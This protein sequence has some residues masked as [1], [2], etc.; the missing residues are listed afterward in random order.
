MDGWTGVEL[1]HL[2]A[3]AAIHE[4]GSFRGAADRLGYVQS[5]VSQQLAQLELLVGTRLVDRARGHAPPVR[6]TEAGVLLLD[7]AGRI[8]GQLAAAEA[9]LRVHA[10]DGAPR[11]R[12]GVDQSVATRLVPAALQHLGAAHP[13]ISVELDEASSDRVHLER[14]AAGELDAAFAELPLGSDSLRFTEVLSDPCV[15]LL[16][17]ASALANADDDLELA[18]LVAAPLVTLAGWPMMNLI[19]SHLRNAGLEP[20]TAMRTNTCT[21]A[22]ALVGTGAGAAILPRL[23]VNEDDPRVVVRD[24]SALLP[25]RTVVLYWHEARLNVPALVA[26]HAATMS[27]ARQVRRGYG[28]RPVASVLAAAPAA[29]PILAAAVPS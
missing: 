24:L 5:A 10:A 8:F 25:S 20:R 14:V 2:A 29:D 1:R 22:Q 3:L 17:R 21:T 26:F 18:D 19:E 4:E 7:H 11:L 12:I 28:G 6:L 27:S 16:P 23:A 9:D 13:G 15:L